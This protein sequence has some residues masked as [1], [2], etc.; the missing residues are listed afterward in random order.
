MSDPNKNKT[1][2]LFETPEADQYF[3]QHLQIENNERIMFSAKFGDGKTTF[4]RRFFE[5]N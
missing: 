3:K 2:E 1:I 4:L 5:K